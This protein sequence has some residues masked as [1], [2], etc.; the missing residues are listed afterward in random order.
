MVCPK[1][2]GRLGQ[3]VPD[4]IFELPDCPFYLPIGLTVAKGDVVM[5]NTK[6]F[7][8]LCKAAHKLSAIIGPDVVWFAPTG[9]KVIV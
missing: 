1:S 7:A 8:Q 3:A 2:C 9:N 6:P 4:T 5:D